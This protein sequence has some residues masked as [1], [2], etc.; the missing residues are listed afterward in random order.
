MAKRTIDLRPYPTPDTDLAAFLYSLGASLL[1]HH[2]DPEDDKV[3]FTFE[4]T[5][6]QERATSEFAAGTAMVNAPAYAKAQKI[7]RTM[8]RNAR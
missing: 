3:Y 5:A 6:E 4:L 2:R 1:N 8:I 7:L